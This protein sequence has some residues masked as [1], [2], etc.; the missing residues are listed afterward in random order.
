MSEERNPR[1]RAPLGHTHQLG[2][3][4]HPELVAHLEVQ[5]QAH[6]CSV[7]EYVRQLII[8]DKRTKEGTA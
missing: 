6:Y 4:L 7:S 5:A 8:D 3:R 2:L 1:A